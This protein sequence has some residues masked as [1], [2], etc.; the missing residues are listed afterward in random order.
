MWPCYII[1]CSHV[2]PPTPPCRWLPVGG[3]R[4]WR[5]E[6]KERRRTGR[7]RSHRRCL[8]LLHQHCPR[9]SLPQPEQPVEPPSGWPGIRREAPW[10]WRRTGRAPRPSR[11]WTRRKRSCWER[12][13]RAPSTT[14]PISPCRARP[15][16]KARPRASSTDRCGG[17]TAS[18]ARTANRELHSLAGRLPPVSPATPSICCH[19]FI[20]TN[21]LAC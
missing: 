7:S 8:S 16:P 6:G 20:P 11:S 15:R 12:T 19:A 21:W 18:S 4:Q 1:N 9:Y 3:R 2:R 13:P 5:R 10:V 17:E 14:S